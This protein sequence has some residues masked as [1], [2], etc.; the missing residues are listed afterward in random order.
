VVLAR[1]YC[2]TR[3]DSIEDGAAAVGGRPEMLLYLLDHPL[4]L[5][6]LFLVL[7]ALSTGIGLRI[8]GR[9]RYGD[10]EDFSVV[11]GAS[12][13]LL[14]LIIAFAFSMAVGRYDQRKNYEEQEANAIG[15]AYVRAGLLPAE[16]GARVRALLRSYLEQRLRFYVAQDEDAVRRIDSETGR[17][18]A[19]LWSA[20]ESH[21]AAQPTP[22]AAIV[23]WGMN[24]VLNS[25]GYTQAAWWNRIPAGAWAMLISIAVFCNLL[26]GYKAA[27]HER[28]WFILLVLPITL[29]VTL[30]LIADIDCPRGGLIH[31]GPHN[32]ESVAASIGVRL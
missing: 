32:L 13:T 31:V 3:A 4:Y 27:H 7:F 14:G 2:A 6:P 18:Q 15:T 5:P 20:V 21:A 28:A 19:E 25:Q 26:V 12:L 17:L 30:F 8:G 24:D 23:A 22:V 16:A 11:L 1:D 9:W 29:S 10:P